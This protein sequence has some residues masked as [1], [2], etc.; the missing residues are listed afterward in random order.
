MMFNR[1]DEL[2]YSYDSSVGAGGDGNRYLDFI[3]DT[4]VPLIQSTYR[5][6][7]LSDPANLGVLGSSLGGLISCYAGWTRTNFGKAGCMSSS[8]WW[9]NEDFNNV[10]LFE[11]EV[12]SNLKVYLDSGNAGIDNDDF[13]QTLRVRDHFEKIGFD[14]NSTLFYYLDNGGQHNEYYWGRRFWVPMSYFYSPS[15]IELN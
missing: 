11:K 4:V 8:F 6:S 14:I 12:S 15:V 10:I 1:T 13:N 3:V 9:H 5:V 2:T 7:D